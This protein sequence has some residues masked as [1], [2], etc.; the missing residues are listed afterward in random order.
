M[1][2]TIE[3]E[4][5]IGLTRCLVPKSNL[6]GEEAVYYLKKY[7]KEFLDFKSKSKTRESECADDYRS[8]ASNVA[9][10]TPILAEG[11]LADFNMVLEYVWCLKKA[12]ASRIYV[13]SN[14]IN[15]LESQIHQIL[16]SPITIFF[17]TSPPTSG[18]HNYKLW[19]L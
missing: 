14:R 1:R 4:T 15:F 18:Q 12:G 13:L 7:G 2:T 8:F 11:F 3:T 9:G 17:L 10:R 5:V 19:P 16:G 6:D